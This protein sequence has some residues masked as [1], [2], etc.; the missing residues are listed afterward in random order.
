M[1]SPSFQ[2]DERLAVLYL[3]LDHFKGVNDTL[4]HQIG[5][6]LLKTVAARLRGCVREADTVARVGG[7]E[8]AIIHTGIEQPND[9][10][11][12]ARR[13]CEAV[14]EPCELHGHAVIVD[15]SIGIALAPGDGSDP[16][17]LSEERRYGALSGQ[18][19]WTRHLPLLRAGDGCAHEGAPDPRARAAN[20]ARQRRVRAALP[21]ARSIWRTAG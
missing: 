11:M 1:R 14:K 19:R 3:D 20:G 17:E 2:R 18:G 9:A 12:L 8:F 10:A 21:A 4:G 5:D 15:T 7:D 13:I 16:T 6:E